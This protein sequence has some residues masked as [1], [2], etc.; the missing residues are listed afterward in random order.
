[1][2]TNEVNSDSYF[3][4]KYI[5]SGG[6]SNN[7]FVI[8]FDSETNNLKVS[9]DISATNISERSLE[10]DEKIKIL[11]L[12]ETNNFMN[13]KDTYITDNE[14]DDSNAVSFSFTVTRGSDIH[15]TKWNE[16]SKDI[17]DGL[18]NIVNEIIKEVK[19]KK[20]I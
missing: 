16:K 7:Y 13:T 3:S 20:M 18:N 9:K 5:E 4:F 2:T 17:P 14:N 6:I 8:S 10:E 19:E 11:E 15:T 12:I 1:M